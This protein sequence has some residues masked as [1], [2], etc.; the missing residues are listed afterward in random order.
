[1]LSKRVMNLRR[2][3]DQQVIFL[4]FSAGLISSLFMYCILLI[5]SYIQ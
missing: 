5:E 3:K 4:L 2:N 1:M